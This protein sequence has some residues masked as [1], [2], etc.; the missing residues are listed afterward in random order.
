MILKKK[1]ET[2]VSIQL[3]ENL[4]RFENRN[5]FECCREINNIIQNT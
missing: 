2:N 1:K 4:I 3:M 5:N